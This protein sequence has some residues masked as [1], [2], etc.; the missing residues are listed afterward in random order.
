MKIHSPIRPDRG[1]GTRRLDMVLH[2]DSNLRFGGRNLQTLKS[3]LPGYGFSL[4]ELMASVSIMMV[5]MGA[6]FS[7]IDYYQKAY[8]RNQ[9]KADMYENVRGV[10]EL[11]AQEIGQAGL[12]DL[13]GA[14]PQLSTAVTP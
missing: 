6:I 10:A 4:L 7:M 12:V 1:Y 14:Q 9:L 8:G 3:S 11:M 13:T 5:I 2:A